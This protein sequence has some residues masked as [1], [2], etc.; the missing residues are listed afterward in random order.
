MKTRHIDDEMKSRSGD[1]IV[2]SANKVIMI[3]SELNY[4]TDVTI[5]TPAGVTLSTFAIAP[6]ETVTTRVARTGV[7]I[8]YADNGK[9][10]KK[11]IVK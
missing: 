1:L 6:D 8:I 11:V 9:Y 3:T 2:K 7:Y 4:K 10:V 5:V